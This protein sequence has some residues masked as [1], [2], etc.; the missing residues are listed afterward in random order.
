MFWYVSDNGYYKVV[1]WWTQ[2]KHRFILHFFS[3]ES[4]ECCSWN[5][6][7][8]WQSFINIQKIKL[9]DSVLVAVFSS[10]SWWSKTDDCGDVRFVLRVN[11]TQVCHWGDMVH[12]IRVIDTHRKNDPT[13]LACRPIQSLHS[14]IHRFVFPQSW[15][16]YLWLSHKQ[17]GNK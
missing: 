12:T 11:D 1:S 15:W 8:S 7:F 2:A 17:Q 13:T 5:I 4:K 9:C 10:G 16:D 3:F 14:L 6:Y